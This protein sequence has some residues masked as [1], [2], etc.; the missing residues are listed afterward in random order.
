MLMHE[1]GPPALQARDGLAAL[2]LLNEHP[3]VVALV[4]T[5]HAL[6]RGPDGESL[7]AAIKTRWPAVKRLLVSTN[8]TS[9]MV[10]AARREG[11]KVVDKEKGFLGITREIKELVDA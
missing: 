10:T 3:G 5:E 9:R 6:E 2:T 7:L 1:K 4:V 8:V 11:F